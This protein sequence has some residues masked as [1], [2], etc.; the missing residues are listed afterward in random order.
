MVALPGVTGMVLRPGR[1]PAAV[2]VTSEQ[3]PSGA[4]SLA[5]PGMLGAKRGLE[6]NTPRNVSPAL[7]GKQVVEAYWVK[8]VVGSSTMISRGPSLECLQEV[9]P[10][11]LPV[12]DTV[13]LM[14]KLA[15]GMSYV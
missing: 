15:L 1:V 9:S 8:P 11:R 12:W 7:A 14:G 2:S 6:K 4:S 3:E 13:L 5:A 10:V